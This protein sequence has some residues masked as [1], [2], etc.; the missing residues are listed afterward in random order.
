[1]ADLVACTTVV[2]SGALIPPKIIFF[3]YVY[4][5]KVVKWLDLLDQI[6][7]NWDSL[8]NNTKLNSYKFT[9]P[10]CKIWWDLKER[11]YSR[12]DW[13]YLV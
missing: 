10:D 8:K 13:M 9:V 12:V 1:M 4:E 11:T 7:M 5:Q 2:L 3:S 6:L